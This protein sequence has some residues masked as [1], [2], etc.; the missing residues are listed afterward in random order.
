MR[1]ARACRPVPM[2]RTST[3][4]I[5][6]SQ[7]DIYGDARRPVRGLVRCLRSCT[8]SALQHMSAGVAWINS[9]WRRRRHPR[10]TSALAVARGHDLDSRSRAQRLAKP[11]TIKSLV[12]RGGQPR[13]RARVARAQIGSDDRPRFMSD[14]AGLSRF[15]HVGSNALREG[16]TRA[17]PRA[18][19]TRSSNPP[20]PF[21][22]PF[23]WPFPWPFPE[24]HSLSVMS[25]W[26][27]G[28]IGLPHAPEG[29]VNAAQNV[30][31][32]IFAARSGIRQ[33]GCHAS[34]SQKNAAD[35]VLRG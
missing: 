1:A 18:H 13:E 9:E 24:A 26:C 17:E 6:T 14:M 30:R 21:P 29:N 25:A 8:A 12:Q 7:D 2:R 16:R 5:T 23:P 31:S 4:D 22:L 10:V 34:L 15:R 27:E 35:I 28:R 20:L 11:D 3:L 19:A 32:K 33:Y